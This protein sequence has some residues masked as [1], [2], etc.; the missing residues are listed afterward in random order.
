MLERGWYALHIQPRSL[1]PFKHHATH[2]GVIATVDVMKLITQLP[3]I[4]RHE[5][6]HAAAPACRRVRSERATSG[7]TLTRQEPR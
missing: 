6:T 2:A 5:L 7:P 1:A 3:L 4:R